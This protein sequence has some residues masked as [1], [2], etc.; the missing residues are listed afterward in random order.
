MLMDNKVANFHAGAYPPG[1]VTDSATML[2]L[3]GL[4]PPALADAGE[5]DGSPGFLT[6]ADV[7]M[8]ADPRRAADSFDLLSLETCDPT[9]HP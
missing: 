3:R 7:L 9:C 2:R 5:H 1:V 6:V 4:E 8:G